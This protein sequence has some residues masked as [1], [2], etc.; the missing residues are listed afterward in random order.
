M[1]QEFEIAT[2]VI[3]T[4]VFMDTETTGLLCREGKNCRIIEM[5]FVAV[6]RE[7]LTDEDPAFPRVLNKLSLCINPRRFIDA[8]AMSIHGKLLYANLV[9]T[10][11][12]VEF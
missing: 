6:L 11:L 4:F 10:G 7:H 1:S 3:R 12:G 9:L 5:C 2:P 8:T